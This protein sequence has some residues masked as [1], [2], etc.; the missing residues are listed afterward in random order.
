M[1]EPRGERRGVR[2]VE[3]L[4]VIEVTD[5]S[6]RAAQLGRT[7]LLVRLHFT[8][9]KSNHRRRLMEERRGWCGRWRA[10]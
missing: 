6:H 10:R 4:P 3:L 1:E 5:Q 8:T 9:A 2:R 7:L